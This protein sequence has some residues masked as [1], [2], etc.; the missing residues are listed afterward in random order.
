MMAKTKLD[1]YVA[2]YANIISGSSSSQM[3]SL[4]KLIKLLQKVKKIVFD[5]ILKWRRP[6]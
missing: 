3:E 6:S 2:P 4:T 5:E 1:P